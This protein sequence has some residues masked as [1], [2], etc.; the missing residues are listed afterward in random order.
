MVR[1]I[2]VLVV[3]LISLG[4]TPAQAGGPTS[5]L[6]SAPP[7]VIAFGYNDQQYSDLQQLVQTTAQHD[8]GTGESHAIGSFV[9][10]TWLIHDMSVWRIDVIY[11]DAPGGPWIATEEFTGE[12]KPAQPTWHR[13]TAPVKLLQLL[14]SLKLLEGEF[15]GGPTLSDEV[16]SQEQP[17]TPPPVQ[18]NVTASPDFFTGWRW[19]IPGILLGA[20]VAVVAVRLFPKRQWDLID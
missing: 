5:V 2:L 13:S 1:R 7:S 11:P 14:T 15:E 19:I 20:A 6:L 12:L 10:A 9:R 4:A 17:T 16:P 8:E 18:T 3:L